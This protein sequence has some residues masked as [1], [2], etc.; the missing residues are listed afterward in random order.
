MFLFLSNSPRSGQNVVWLQSSL[1]TFSHMLN[2]QIPFNRDH[3]FKLQLLC[4]PCWCFSQAETLLQ[5]TEAGG[6][7]FL[8][9]CGY[10]RGPRCVIGRDPRQRDRRGC[11]C[12]CAMRC[13]DKITCLGLY[14]EVFTNLLCETKRP[15]GIWLGRHDR[16]TGHCVCDLSLSTTEVRALLGCTMHFGSIAFLVDNISEQVDA[17]LS[18]FN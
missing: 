8:S 18:C 6:I 17:G 5:D 10:L 4:R 15:R 9:R 16:K 2:S 3:Y 12:A 11:R 14:V 7:P 13:N 1:F